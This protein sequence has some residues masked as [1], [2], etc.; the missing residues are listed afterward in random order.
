MYLVLI[1]RELNQF[2]VVD[3]AHP[4]LQPSDVPVRDELARHI[5]LRRADRLKD[6]ENARIPDRP[7][8]E[9][10]TNRCQDKT[11]SRRRLTTLQATTIRRSSR[12]SQS[13]GQ[14]FQPER[15]RLPGV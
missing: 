5:R 4:G 15:T 10:R 8:Q 12:D 6:S 7:R 3:I 11:T 14:A 1:Q 13:S 2:G 9:R